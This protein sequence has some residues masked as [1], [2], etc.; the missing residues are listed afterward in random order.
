MTFIAIPVCQR[1][2]QFRS[3][4]FSFRFS[5]SLSLS[6]FRFL[7]SFVPFLSS[8][9]QTFHNIDRSRIANRFLSVLNSCV[10][11]SWISCRP[12][13]VKVPA[14]QLIDGRTLVDD[15]DSTRDRLPSDRPAACPWILR[16][17]SSSRHP[18]GSLSLSFAR[19]QRALPSLSRISGHRDKR[20]LLRL[21]RFFL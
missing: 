1:V 7:R 15:R 5:L 6:P 19:T 3:S 2:V 18:L 12:A 16:D 20:T 8:N 14:K 13:R 10:S 4:P 9:S 21:I 11:V 17:I